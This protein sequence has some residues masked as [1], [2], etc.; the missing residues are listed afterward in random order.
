M[1][2]NGY[3]PSNW[4]FDVKTTKMAGAAI[5]VFA[6]YRG[7]TNPMVETLEHA[8]TKRLAHRHLRNIS[9]QTDTY[10][11][12]AA[13]RA[14]WA[15]IQKEKKFSF[16]VANFIGRAAPPQ[17]SLDEQI[18]LEMRAGTTPEEMVA[19]IMARAA[20]MQENAAGMERPAVLLDEELNDLAEEENEIN[21]AA[22]A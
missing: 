15:V 12:T 18:E 1:G 13:D 6:Q 5:T 22:A 11:P 8:E 2:S 3:I 16:V 4:S 19:R 14:L 17:L 10:K 21:T 7:M 9:G 20:A